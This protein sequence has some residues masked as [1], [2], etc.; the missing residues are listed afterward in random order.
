[1][2]KRFPRQEE[3]ILKNQGYDTDEDVLV[4]N[5]EV[6]YK[7]AWLLGLCYF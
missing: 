3:E 7:E 2:L 6:K 1:V 4:D 5:P